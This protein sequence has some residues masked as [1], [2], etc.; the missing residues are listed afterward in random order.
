MLKTGKFVAL[1]IMSVLA[2]S[3]A[4][5]EDKSAALVNGVSI[6]Q[7]L[8]DMSVEAAVA[9]GK[10]KDT[11]ELRKGIRDDLINREVISQEATRI[12]LDKK[13]EIIQQTRMA[14]Q[15]VLINAFVKDYL[16]GHPISDDQLKKEYAKATDNLGNKQYKARHILVDSE[17]KAKGIIAELGKKAKFDKLAKEKSK[18]AGSA[19]Q[20]GELDWA[21]PNSFVPTFSNAM[22]KLKKG[23]YTKKPVQSQFG[24]HVI[25][26]DDVR[27]MEA[28]PFEEVKPQIQQRLQQQAIQDAISDLR[29]KAKIE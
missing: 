26:L 16:K 6:P 20:G 21:A 11:P 29:D 4:F 24:W 23:K 8:I 10:R 18:D 3:P 9:Q 25:K 19:E 17:A 7:S 22:I 13:P 12:G 15:S 5:A 28:P 14:R 27:N 1:A 2:S